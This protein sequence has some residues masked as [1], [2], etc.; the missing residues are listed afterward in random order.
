MNPAT[1]PGHGSS[2]PPLVPR[3]H[4]VSA[5]AAVVAALAGRDR[6]QLHMA[7]G[8]GKTLVGIG[9]A[10]ALGATRTAVVVPSLALVAQTVRDWSPTL[11]P[12]TRILILCSDPST[13]AGSGELDGADRADLPFN[14]WNHQRATGEHPTVV[15]TDA[16][17]AGAYLAAS[18]NVL[19]VST[20]HSAPVL[21]EAVH[22]A[23]TPLDLLIADEAHHLAG[24]VN[25]LF[26]PV[27]VGGALPARKRLFMTATPIVLTNT[28]L[29]GLDDVDELAD[30]LDGY[31]GAP[32]HAWASMDDQGL[33][34]AAAYRYTTRAAITDG[35]LCDYK[36]VVVADR[37]LTVGDKRLPLAALTTATRAHN[38]RRVLSFHNRVASATTFAALA[39]GYT[40]PDLTFEAD[41]VNSSTKT[42]DTARALARLA[43]PA[44]DGVTRLVSA[45]K[46]LREGVDVAGVD[47]VVF[48][49]PRSSTVDIIQ[50]IGRA[51]R[52]YPGKA[53]GVIIIPV[54]LP[55]R[56][57]D[58]EDL[59]LSPFGHV[60]RILRGLNAH[61]PRVADSLQAVG[62]RV[63]H[64]GRSRSGL[65]TDWLTIMGGP[66]VDTDSVLTR[67][68]AGAAP[69]WD[70]MYNLT[71]DF[72]RE[73]GG[74]HHITTSTRAGKHSLGG[75]V[76]AQR[77]LHRKHLLSLDRAEALAL[78]PGWTWA[79]EHQ[80]DLRMLDTLAAHVVAA[81]TS[82]DA[83]AG[84]T[85]YPANGRQ[86]P[87]GRWLA[88][89]RRAHAENVVDPAVAT[90]LETLPGFTW[91]PLSRP[92]RAGVEAFATF[93]LWEKHG[94]V[95]AGHVE[96]GVPLAD[97]LTG[98]G[99]QHLAGTLSPELRE[100]LL[101]VAPVS[102]SGDPVFAWNVAALRFG[103]GVAGMYQYY[104]REHTLA[105]SSTHTETVHGVPVHLYQWAARLRWLQ[106]RGQLTAEQAVALAAIP[107][108]SWDLVAS[109][110]PKGA[111]M[112]LPDG[113]A[114]GT[115]DAGSNYRC[116]CP[117]CVKVVRGAM[118]S[119]KRG[120][121]EA[122]AADWRPCPK[123][124]RNVTALAM[125]IPHVTTRMIADALG[126]PGTLLRALIADH[127]A[128]VPP[129]FHTA[130]ETITASDVGAWIRPGTRGRI[131]GRGDVP[132][133]H[134]LVGQLLG[135]LR[136]AGWTTLA[137]TSA[138]GYCGSAKL[139]FSATRV[140]FAQ[141]G[142][143]ELL[144]AH[145]GADLTPPKWYRPPPKARTRNTAGR[146]K[147][148]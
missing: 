35:Y 38:L 13:A 27:L 67:L 127:D 76:I 121:K 100:E 80:G 95:P 19:V 139:P 113:V 61:D 15:T 143:L 107:C 73:H 137:L 125:T 146:A 26:R 65:D 3:P 128:R 33:F 89:V 28:G 44:P 129:R 88:R 66:D 79:P 93:V 103:L 40:S 29:P 46:C 16:A 54:A 87:L 124:A 148:A 43:E 72:A 37:G 68:V 69:R 122:F 1:P 133:D 10:A 7:C 99:Y 45:A 147:T 96:G 105:M 77:G 49:D 20:Y 83:A 58:D 82:A 123:G 70:R 9:V 112:A 91:E 39:A 41:T 2:G 18:G 5:I 71:M 55:E 132:G 56:A 57:D 17:R 115:L 90:A 63:D 78:I 36:V 21:A 74:A 6:T 140:T 52:P 31:G 4:Q 97:W 53:V 86:A 117:P 59:A 120:R 12:G 64:R 136:D 34:G 138:L 47:G 130:L 131:A 84:P 98:L 101:A 32:E 118:S 60:W 92:D 30:E 81:G 51:L 114:H 126:M 85:G 102:N 48:A 119:W 135:R 94:N 106:R 25:P 14:R 110:T 42:V 22:E 144:V 142:A 116:P 23:G 104:E 62:R 145:L 50:C 108:W 11:A 109:R 24:K 141:Q 8:S 75:F 111:P 134:D